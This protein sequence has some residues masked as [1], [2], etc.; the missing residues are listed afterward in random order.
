MWYVYILRCSDDSFYVGLTQDLDARVKAHNDGQ[1]AAYTFRRR[2]VRL[3]HS[4]KFESE[5]KGIER[6]RQL[7]HWSHSKKEALVSGNLQ[8]LK[9]LSNS[10]S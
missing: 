2:P 3:V 4:E 1:G 5:S 6:E 10:R 7:K 8:K 9:R